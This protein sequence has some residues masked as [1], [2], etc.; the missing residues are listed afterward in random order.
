MLVPGRHTEEGRC[1]GEWID[2]EEDCTDSRNPL[3]KEGVQSSSILAHA[4]ATHCVDSHARLVLSQECAARALQV[5]AIPDLLR[6]FAYRSM[7][8]PLGPS[9]STIECQQRS[10][11]ARC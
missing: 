7:A 9:R 11:P 2:D 8:V 6:R 3:G 1:R 5:T 10:F 4:G